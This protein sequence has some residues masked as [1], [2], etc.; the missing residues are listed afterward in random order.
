MQAGTIAHAAAGGELA[1]EA[2]GDFPN[3][4][5]QLGV[6]EPTLDRPTAMQTS[7]TDQSVVRNNAAARSSRR[8]SRYWC[9]DSP[10]VRLNSR[11][12]CACESRAARAMSTTPIASE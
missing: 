3:K 6:N 5:P 2:V 9:G 4:R 11:L 12:K 1:R 10:N 7:A 8:V